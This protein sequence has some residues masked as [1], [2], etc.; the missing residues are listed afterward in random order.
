M[1]EATLTP[2]LQA[3]LSEGLD[4]LLGVETKEKLKFTKEQYELRLQYARLAW[5]LAS[6]IGPWNYETQ[7]KTLIISISMSKALGRTE[8][9]FIKTIEDTF[10]AVA[11]IADDPSTEAV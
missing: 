10:A 4:R 9:Q 7:S 1:S 5:R 6:E 11:T 8:D 2:E 3:K